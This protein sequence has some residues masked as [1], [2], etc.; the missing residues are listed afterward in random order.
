MQFNE[1]K[2]CDAVLRWIEQR[3][4]AE[5]SD[6][7]WP[8]KEHDAAPVELVCNIGKQQF[9]LEHTGVEPFEGFMRLQNDAIT[10]FRPLEDRIAQ[11]LPATEYIELHMPLRAT[12]GL[13]GRTLSSVQDALALYVREKA[14]TLPLAREG[15]YVLPIEHEIPPG[16]PFPVTMHRWPRSWR[17]KSFAIVQKIEGDLEAMRSVRIVKTC[18]DKFP[19]L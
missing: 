18:N 5:R 16:V 17:A 6:I 3:E 8:E 7:R 13:R 14:P 2:A 15:R 10:H 9:A 11:H 1:G 4:R 12:E 19:K